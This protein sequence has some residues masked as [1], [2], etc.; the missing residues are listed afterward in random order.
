MINTVLQLINYLR[1]VKLRDLIDKSFSDINR[2]LYHGDNDKL[3]LTDTDIVRIDG[4]SHRL[5]INTN[6]GNLYLVKQFKDKI[7][8]TMYV[9]SLVDLLDDRLIHNSV[10][11]SNVLSSF[12][13]ALDLGVMS[14]N[15]NVTCD[16]A[17]YYT[18]TVRW[19]EI[20]NLAALT[21]II[22]EV[23]SQVEMATTHV[24]AHIKMLKD[25]NS[26]DEEFNLEESDDGEFDNY[27]DFR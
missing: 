16:M 10:V 19:N 26:L 17:L 9:G 18:T 20:N 1:L 21:T 14:L 2:Q 24:M 23:S 7:F 8:F 3:Y 4:N 13:E 22:K 27:A 25:F 6:I 12:N 15:N 5:Y 11:V